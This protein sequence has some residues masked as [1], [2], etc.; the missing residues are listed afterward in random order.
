MVEREKFLKLCTLASYVLLQFPTKTGRSGQAEG[1]LMVR[2]ANEERNI[3]TQL[4]SGSRNASRFCFTQ[5]LGL[6]RK[7]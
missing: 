3:V 7:I 2:S 1:R 5:N 4:T 6:I